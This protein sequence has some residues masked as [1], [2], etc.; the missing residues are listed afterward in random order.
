VLGVRRLDELANP[1][2]A[3]SVFWRETPT[4]TEWQRGRGSAD[5]P[6]QE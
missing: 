3:S 5:L 4:G 2:E 6:S 1:T